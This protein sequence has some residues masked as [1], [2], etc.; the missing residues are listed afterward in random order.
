MEVDKIEKENICVVQRL[1]A[2]PD[3][4]RGLRLE[5]DGGERRKRAGSDR[6]GC[7]DGRGGI[8]RSRERRRTHGSTFHGTGECE[9]AHRPADLD[10]R[11]H[12]QTSCR[13]NGE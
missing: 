8:F 12:R 3:C 11:R 13:R 6:N 2:Q 5:T 10:G 1:A 7:S 9:P 4:V